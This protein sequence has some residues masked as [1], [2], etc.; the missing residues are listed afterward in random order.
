MR[1]ISFP[2]D[3]PFPAGRSGVVALLGPDDPVG[4]GDEQLEQRFF[5]IVQLLLQVGEL[6]FQLG[7]LLV[8]GRRLGMGQAGRQQQSAQ[9]CGQTGSAATTHQES[10]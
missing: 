6:F 5:E 1:I 2:A 9:D 4:L 8:P 3:E 10:G 7:D